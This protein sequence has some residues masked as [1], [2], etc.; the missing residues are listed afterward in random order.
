MSG[1]GDIGQVAAALLVRA[2]AVGLPA[3]ILERVR[4]DGSGDVAMCEAVER[5]VEDLEASAA[6][7]EEL[8]R[9]LAEVLP[10][11]EVSEDEAERLQL[12]A[13]RQ[14]ARRSLGREAARAM[15]ERDPGGALAVLDDT[16]ET[17]SLPEAEPRAHQRVLDLAARIGGQ[18]AIPTL[19]AEEHAALLEVQY[20]DQAMGV[21]HEAWERINELSGKARRRLSQVK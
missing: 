17:R 2:E 3:R 1:R 6:H 20:P 8:E 11:R 7:G 10:P 14:R 9:R 16:E 19:S 18:G 15:A 13:A 21:I 4:Q 5:W 12:D